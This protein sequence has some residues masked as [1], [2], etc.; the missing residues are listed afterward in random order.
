MDKYAI[1]LDIGTSGFRAQ[2][3][4]LTFND[5]VSTCIT[6]HHPLPGE[7]SIDH[8]HFAL[9]YGIETASDC[10]I[11]TINFVIKKLSIPINSIIRLAI[12]G[13]PVQLSIFQGIEIEDLAYAG[14]RK[15]ELLN[16][17]NIDRKACIRTGSDFPDLKIPDTC[18]VIIPPAVFDQV[19]ADAIALILQSEMQNK[20]EV[21][22]AIDLGT[23]AEIALC[24]NKIISTTSAAAGPAIE[25]QQISCGMLAA[26]GAICDIVSSGSDY[27]LVILNSDMIPETGPSINLKSGKIKKHNNVIAKGITG[28]GII[29]VITDAI[30]DG[31]IVLP[32]ICT[33]DKKLHL[34]DKI[35]LTEA[36]LNEA[37]K[38]FGAIRAGYF[39]LC[40]EAGIH[41][42]D[43][44]TAY[45]SG[46]SGTY[47]DALKA[48][49]AGLI[50]PS[51]KNIFQLGNTSLLMARELA[52][53]KNKLEEMVSL[54]IELKKTHFMLAKSEV[55][56]KVYI[57]EMAYW[58]EGMPMQQYQD[59]L[60]KYGYKKFTSSFQ[61]S[62]T[63]KLTN[64]D[65]DNLGKYGLKIISD[66]GRIIKRNITGCTLC[67]KCMTHCPQKAISI[68]SDNNLPILFLNESLCYGASCRKCENVCPEKVF[69]L[70]KFFL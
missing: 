8:L 10:M 39:S 51:V 45:I 64:R 50:P 35:E 59:F 30:K 55:F 14:S 53:N 31:I 2:A 19:G 60:M 47:V 58:N 70:D 27:N 16:I 46:A 12:C 5:V 62:K 7:N 48:Q 9:E 15:L 38:A 63:H 25:G 43:I 4:N 42:D 17:K 56:K 13:N 61:H 67:K 26:P 3:I 52:L 23:N 57:L 33:E 22:I 41:I 6:T 29:A 32:H 24:N 28:T 65:I 69:K 36:D 37:G 40:H 66:F 20:D 11:R 18:E 68:S 54:S 21:S 34:T 1:A 44:K 49:K